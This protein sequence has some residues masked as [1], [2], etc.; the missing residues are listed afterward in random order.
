MSLLTSV[1]Q[2]TRIAEQQ[3]R[4]H[5][6]RT[7]H[8]EAAQERGR[9]LEPRLSHGMDF[10]L[11]SGAAPESP[12][13]GPRRAQEHGGAGGPKSESEE[14]RTRKKRKRSRKPEAQPYP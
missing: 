11:I 10:V 5:S 7:E 6:R 9:G 12:G 3:L 1:L 8:A 4:R 13:T 14:Q 2:K